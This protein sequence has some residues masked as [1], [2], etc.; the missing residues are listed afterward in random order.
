MSEELLGTGPRRPEWSSVASCLKSSLRPIPVGIS[1]RP[2]R[3][4]C[5]N[6]AE[7]VRA[8]PKGKG[9]QLS[10]HTHSFSFIPPPCFP[11]LL[12]SPSTS[13]PFLS[14]PLPFSPPIPH[15]PLFLSL[16]LSPSPFS[17]IP[18]GPEEIVLFTRKG[19][20]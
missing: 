9:L 8:P 17:V 5:R 6:Q 7:S 20:S 12:L 16:S 13:P 14:Y 19:N 3:T 11:S 2:V 4:Y 15:T 10:L 18:N 1:A